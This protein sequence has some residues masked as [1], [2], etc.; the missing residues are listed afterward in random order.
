VFNINY[1]LSPKHPFPAALIDCSNALSYALREAARL[2]G[3]PRRLVLAGESAG[4]NLATALTL[5]T[6]VR[7]SEP[8]AQKVY[9][10]GQVPRAVLPMCGVLQVSD[11]QRFARRRPLP[12]FLHDRLVEVANSYLHSA[13]AESVALADPLLM[14]E[15]GPALDRP[16]PPIFAGVGTRDP[17]LDDTRR[18]GQALS[19]L[20]SAHEI[21]YYPGEVHAFHALVYRAQ[22][23]ACWRDQFAFL[24][25]HLGD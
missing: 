19:R 5:L 16:L 20:G 4:A 18:L 23:R 25:R 1:R 3:D 21:R 24:A 7:R 17:L 8:W 9:A 22:A 11:P 10:L 2:G 15:D 6:C 14:L 13:P 12:A